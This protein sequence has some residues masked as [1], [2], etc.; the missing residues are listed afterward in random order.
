VGAQ[1]ALGHHEQG[2]LP[3]LRPHL[4]LLDEGAGVDIELSNHGFADYGLERMEQLRSAPDGRQNPFVVGTPSA[5]RFMKVVETMLRG[6][7]AQDQEAATPAATTM[8]AT[9]TRTTAC[10]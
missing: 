10:C 7:I 9:S 2:D 1:P 8:A 4:R 6:R 5:Q 3:P